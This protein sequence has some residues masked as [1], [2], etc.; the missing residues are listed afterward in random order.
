[1]SIKY[2]NDKSKQV[3][4]I[5]VTIVIFINSN[6]ED[7]NNDIKIEFEF[8]NKWFKAKRLSLNFDKI[9][10]LQLH[11]SIVLKLIWT[12]VILTYEFLYH[13]IHVCMYVCI[14]VCM[15]A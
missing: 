15:H 7:E 5:G 11:L 14:Y 10:F 9:Y 3:P 4:L 12:L 8:L 6:L 2:V 13:M 1:M